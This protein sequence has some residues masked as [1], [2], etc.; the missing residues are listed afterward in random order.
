MFVIKYDYNTASDDPLRN[1]VK[2]QN[3]EGIYLLPLIRV[4]ISASYE[5]KQVIK[6]K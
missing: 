2:I 4:T 3:K 5:K 6:I 1:I